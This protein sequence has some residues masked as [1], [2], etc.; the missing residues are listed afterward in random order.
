MFTQL[1]V[2]GFKALRDV[3]IPLSPFTLILGPNGCG[4]TSVLEAIQFLQNQGGSTL[5]ESQLS[6]GMAVD[7]WE[8]RG[9]WRG[10]QGE[11]TTLRKHHSGLEVLPETRSS[12]LN[13][14]AEIY[15][16]DAGQISR[17]C[18]IGVGVRLGSQGEGLSAVWDALRDQ[19]PEAF[20]RLNLE[21]QRLLPE[22]DRILLKTIDTGTKIF[23]LR[24]KEGHHAISARDLS[25]GTRM[26]LALLTLNHLPQ[27]PDVLCLE[28]PDHGLHPRLLRDVRD[29]LYRLSYPEDP[30]VKPMQVIATT[31]NPYF[32]ELFQDHPEEIVIASKTGLSASFTRLSELPNS[33]E[34]LADAPLGD[35]W[36]SGLLGGVPS[37]T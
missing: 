17:P 8:I 7:S 29:V 22:Y 24:T 27:R 4:K 37:L 9:H 34:I 10:A 32:L 25:Q 35:C 19:H 14:R 1:D 28:E 18:K 36:Y 11:E 5:Q 3:S 13:F 2:C 21:V 15:S 33:A 31:H 6:V 16:L 23:E 30:G 12:V 20:E 26:A